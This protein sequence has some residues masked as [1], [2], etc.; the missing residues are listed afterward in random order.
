MKGSVPY[1]SRPP[2]EDNGVFIIQ[3]FLWSNIYNMWGALGLGFDF[4]GGHT[5]WQRERDLEREERERES[6]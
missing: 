5:K 6:L 2:E 1:N 3:V 4:V